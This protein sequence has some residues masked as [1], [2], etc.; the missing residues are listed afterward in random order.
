MFYQCWQRFWKWRI[1]VEVRRG[2]LVSTQSIVFG[3]P[4]CLV[5]CKNPHND[6][7]VDLPI[8]QGFID[9]NLMGLKL[10][11]LDVIKKNIFY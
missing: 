5:Y 1:N 11:T 8:G 4:E 2:T 9:E 10:I 3:R 7:L 6:I